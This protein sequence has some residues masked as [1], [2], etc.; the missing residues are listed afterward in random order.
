MFVPKITKICMTDNSD[1]LFIKWTVPPQPSAIQGYILAF[2]RSDLDLNF[3]SVTL[4]GAN[5]SSHA[6]ALSR[7]SQRYDLK[8]SAFTS[9]QF[10]DFSDLITWCSS[11]FQYPRRQN[12]LPIPIITKILSARGGHSINVYWRIPLDVSSLIVENFLVLYKRCGL[13]TEFKEKLVPGSEVTNHVILGLSECTLYEVR[14]AACTSTLRGGF[15][16]PAM[17][18]TGVTKPDSIKLKTSRGPDYKPNITNLCETVSDKRKLHIAWKIPD[19]VTYPP[20]NGY[21]IALRK[22][23]SYETPY[24]KYYVRDPQ[25]DSHVIH[26]IHEQYP[27][28]VKMAAFNAFGEGKFTRTLV[29]DKSRTKMEVRIPQ[30]L[31]KKVRELFPRHFQENV[32]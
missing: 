27:Y 9:Q 15:S 5:V 8:I 32:T 19:H 4:I 6:I 2:R 12:L 25:K 31:P 17:L 22:T 10:G 14:V 20:V 1:G 29:I 3:S 28:E 11:E 7:A 16:A 26:D 18:R 21:V 24:T 13:D 30:L 23:S